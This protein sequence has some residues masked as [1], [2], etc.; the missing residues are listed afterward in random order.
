MIECFHSLCRPE[1]LC[2]PCPGPGQAGLLWTWPG[3][4]RRAW[5]LLLP[6]LTVT[7]SQVADSMA[8][9]T[10][11]WGPT[12]NSMGGMKIILG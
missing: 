1:A 8:S 5:R 12:W 2:S 6:A 3:V 4:A 7:T 10:L 9:F 11:V